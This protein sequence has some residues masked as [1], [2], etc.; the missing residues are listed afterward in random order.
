MHRVF[1]KFLVDFYVET[2]QV[3]NAIEIQNEIIETLNRKEWGLTSRA[4]LYHSNGQL[5]EALKDLLLA[6][7]LI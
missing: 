7:S 3:E 6:K 4:E 5:S 2:G 1:Q